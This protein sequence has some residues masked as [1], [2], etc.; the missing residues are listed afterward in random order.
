MCY[1]CCAVDSNN[2]AWQ[3]P[4]TYLLFPSN[5]CTNEKDSIQYF[6]ITPWPQSSI[7]A[8]GA[9]SCGTAGADNHYAKLRMLCTT[10]IF[11]LWPKEIQAIDAD[12]WHMQP[13]SEGNQSWHSRKLSNMFTCMFCQICCWLFSH[14]CKAISTKLTQLEPTSTIIIIGP[15][16][17]SQFCTDYLQLIGQ[18]LANQCA[19]QQKC[20][21]TRRTVAIPVQHRPKPKIE[22]LEQHNGVPK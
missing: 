6:M 1:A 18:C 13:I 9:H 15:L 17:N 11:E 12:Q 14:K 19:L 7:N 22:P 8:M 21:S 2:S 5:S 20:S 16:Q 3:S 4:E 10:P